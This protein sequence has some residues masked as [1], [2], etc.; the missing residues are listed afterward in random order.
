MK[1]TAEQPEAPTLE[2]PKK[3]GNTYYDSAWRWIED[4]YLKYFGENRTS[5]GVKGKSLFPT[6]CYL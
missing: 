2:T 6:L 5:Y 3:T 4:T 1:L